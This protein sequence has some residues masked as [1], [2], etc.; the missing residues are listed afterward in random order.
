M[1]Q[2]LVIRQIAGMEA[3]F[4]F[5]GQPVARCGAW[6]V[7]LYQQSGAE[8]PWRIVASGTVGNCFTS[9]SGQSL[10]ERPSDEEFIATATDMFESLARSG[11]L[12]RA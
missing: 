11:E 6:T 1:S 5:V 9:Y 12:F 7:D 8:G 4:L 3:T 2:K 10:R